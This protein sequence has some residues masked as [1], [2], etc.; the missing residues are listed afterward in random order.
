MR[1]VICNFA[2]PAQ[3]LE[4]N[5]IVILQIQYHGVQLWDCFGR[6]PDEPWN[7]PG[8]VP[9]TNMQESL[10]LTVDPNGSMYEIGNDRQAFTLNQWT[11]NCRFS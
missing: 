2:T 8:C 4:Q 7:D 5:W 1:I 6:D 3:H 9:V 11:P 10:Q